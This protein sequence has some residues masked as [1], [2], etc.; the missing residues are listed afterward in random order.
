MAFA[1]VAP[2]QGSLIWL[3][4]GV[5]DFGEEKQSFKVLSSMSASECLLPF[6]AHLP[7]TS[8]PEMVTHHCVEEEGES[9]GCSQD[10]EDGLASYQEHQASAQLCLTPSSRGW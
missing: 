9:E 6:E 10:A 1:Y 4:V 3:R 2:K 7:R 8:G 5:W